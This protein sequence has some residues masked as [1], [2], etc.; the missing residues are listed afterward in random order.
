MNKKS[1]PQMTQMNADGIARSK[2]L[3]KSASSA[4]KGESPAAPDPLFGRIVTIL[5][6]ARGAVVRV[7]E[8][9]QI[10]S[11][12]LRTLVEDISGRRS[13]GSVGSNLCQWGM[14]RRGGIAYEKRAST[15]CL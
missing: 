6:Q 1:N 10:G 2:H 14:N 3:R 4:D 7:R 15:G 13:M 11:G 5:E 8:I 9:R 12:V